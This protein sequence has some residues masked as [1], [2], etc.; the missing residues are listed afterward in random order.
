MINSDY[1]FNSLI[2]ADIIKP[3]IPAKDDRIKSVCCDLSN[4]LAIEKLITK[5]TSVVFH[6]AAI[7][8]SHAEADFDLGVK[9]NL[10]T[11]R[12]L[13]ERCRQT[14]PSIR[15]IFTS[16]LAVF[17]GELPDVITD[18]TLLAPQSSYGTQKAI[19]ELLVNDYARKGFVDARTLRLP[20]IAIRP[21]KPNK[22]ASSF[23]SG[24]IREPLNNEPSAC[25]VSPDLKLWLSSPDT[26]IQNLIHL[27]S[28]S[29]DAF[30]Y[31]R[32]IN[33]PGISVTVEQML[34][35]LAEA[36]GGE[37]KDL[38]TFTKDEAVN[39]IVSS[40]PSAID[41]KR[42]LSLG[43]SVD[44]D[45]YSIIDQYITHEMQGVVK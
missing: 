28:L 29:K 22:A 6:L 30:P 32:T 1:S 36:G 2:L 7:V 15:F 24:I 10:D 44:A 39:R 41:N 45:F 40:W 34:I 42:A 12:N 25:P 13:L 35:C 23:V 31:W 43:F 16:S 8:S 37:K 17:G 4:S 21:G 38:V 11:T 18:T 19:G 20:T 3:A 33:A 26:I 9:I 27:S 14:N 5:E